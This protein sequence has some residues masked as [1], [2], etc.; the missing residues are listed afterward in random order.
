M[1][2]ACPYSSFNADFGR[3]ADWNTSKILALK[4]AALTWI[5]G[6]H[7]ILADP[8]FVVFIGDNVPLT[9][10][11]M[12]RID[13]ELCRQR[14]LRNAQR[15]WSTMDLEGGFGVQNRLVAEEELKRWFY[16]PQANGQ[17]PLTI[18]PMPDSVKEIVTI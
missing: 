5:K 16:E 9:L 6:F 14:H 8:T 18:V 12:H 7:D 13:F 17:E 1:K 2:R 10:L 11:H 4:V 15:K 3:P